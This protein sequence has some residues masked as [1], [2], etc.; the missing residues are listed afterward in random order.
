MQS[1]FWLCYIIA[2]KNFKPHFGSIKLLEAGDEVTFTDAEGN[3]FSYSVS[4]TETLDG[5]DIEGMQTGDWDLTLFTCTPGGQI[6]VAV[7]CQEA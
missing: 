3:I 5:Y 7:R 4:E 2:A 6:R 1:A